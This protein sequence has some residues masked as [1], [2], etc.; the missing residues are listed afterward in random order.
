MPPGFP[1]VAAAAAGGTAAHPSAETGVDRAPWPGYPSGAT[2]PAERGRGSGDGRDHEPADASL[3][4]RQ[5]HPWHAADDRARR[6]AAAGAGA[7]LA[8]DRRR[9]PRGRVARGRGGA[10]RPDDP[11][12]RSDRGRASERSRRAARDPR[13]PPPDRH[14]GADARH[15][16]PEAPLRR[17][18][19]RD[20]RCAG[21]ARPRDPHGRRRPRPP[22]PGAPPDRAA[23]DPGGR[24]PGRHLRGRRGEIGRPRGSRAP[25]GG[26]LGAGFL[27]AGSVIAS[28]P[29]DGVHFEAAAHAALGQAVAAGVAA[30]MERE[31]G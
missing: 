4:W 9:G 24:V 2:G 21:P 28:S 3:L 17:V 14:R 16:R 8:R 10:A 31:A 19:R 22:G 30:Q 29:V 11:A 20:R 6:A 1:T 15:Q 27:D 23:A 13:E 7:A 5:Q 26:D 25:D 18:G 12:S